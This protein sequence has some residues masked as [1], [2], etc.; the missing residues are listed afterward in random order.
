MSGV[1]TIASRV[2]ARGGGAAAHRNLAQQVTV[3]VLIA[4]LP[5]V[6]V[7]VGLLVLTERSH[8]LAGAVDRE[9]ALLTSSLYELAASPAF[10]CAPSADFQSQAQAAA[11]RH[12]GWIVLAGSDGRHR[13]STRPSRPGVS[14]V[15]VDP[16]SGSPA[17]FVTVPV[18]GAASAPC[19]LS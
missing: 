2:L 5:L 3:L 12:G 7:A 11:V 1:G 13:M 19:W 16:V 14:G 4:S 15:V 17:V 10:D 6:A 8:A 18:A 9:I